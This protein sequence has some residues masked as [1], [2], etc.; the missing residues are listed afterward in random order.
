[1]TDRLL[2]LITI[3]VVS[4]RNVEQL[5]RLHLRQ[6]SETSAWA[7]SFCFIQEW[8]ECITCSAII[9]SRMLHQQHIIKIFQQQPPR[10]DEGDAKDDLVLLCNAAEKIE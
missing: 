8:K 3:V 2:L 6:A 1:M 4:S 5:R 10:L 9:E 7:M